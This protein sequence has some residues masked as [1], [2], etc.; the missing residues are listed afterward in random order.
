MSGYKLSKTIYFLIMNVRG[1]ACK[2]SM[3][4]PTYPK[5][6]SARCLVWEQLAFVLEQL[7]RHLLHGILQRYPGFSLLLLFGSSEDSARENPRLW[8]TVTTSL[9][10]ICCYVVML[11]CRCVVTERKNLRSRIIVLPDRPLYGSDCYVC[12]IRILDSGGHSARCRAGCIAPV[13]Q[14]QGWYAFLAP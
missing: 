4:L 3:P 2:I 11:L 8:S 10:A 6:W 5:I 13:F 7:G 12:C 14:L 1:C 9:R